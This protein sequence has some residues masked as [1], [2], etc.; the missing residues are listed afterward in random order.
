MEYKSNKPYPP[1]EV[2]S[3]N[4]YYGELL[5]EDLAGMVSEMSAIS[6]Y[7]Y[8]NT[9]ILP[10]LEQLKEAFRKI[11]MVEMRH[12]Q[13]LNDLV[14][15]LGV[16]PRLWTNNQG[17]CQYWTPFYN[18]YPNQ[19]EALLINSINSEQQ[20]I[21]QYQNHVRCIQ[22]PK[23]IAILERIIEDEVIHLNIFKSFY[24]SLVK[25]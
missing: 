15:Q 19:L 24:N 17:Q 16:D 11:N 13:I 9:I 3:K 18:S 20:A 10:E 7:M 2:S 22:D 8:N 1:V 6:L 23:I 4:I 5:L 21:E 12:L 14:L 25:H